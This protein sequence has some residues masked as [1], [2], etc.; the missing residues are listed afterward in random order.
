MLSAQVEKLITRK[1]A[2]VLSEA[3]SKLRA[4]IPD[5]EEEVDLF[6]S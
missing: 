1:N 5:G 3:W 4:D 6:L 2:T